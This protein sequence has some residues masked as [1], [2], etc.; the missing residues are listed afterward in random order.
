MLHDTARPTS[1]HR[2]LASV[3][4]AHAH[5][6]LGKPE[7]VELLLAGISRALVNS[8]ESNARDPHSAWALY[9]EAYWDHFE[10]NIKESLLVAFA[11]TPPALREAVRTAVEDTIRH[12]KR[13]YRFN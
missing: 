1:G 3:H 4:A 9:S 12:L 2:L 13:A 5:G 7:A 8:V 6:V 11:G 10:M